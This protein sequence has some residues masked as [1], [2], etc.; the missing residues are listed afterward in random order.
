MKESGS[1][2][3]WKAFGLNFVDYLDWRP[4]MRGNSKKSIKH[5]WAHTTR[6][7]EKRE[8]KKELETELL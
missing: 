4:Q 3:F 7:N 8:T 2:R 5:S 6:S 1:K